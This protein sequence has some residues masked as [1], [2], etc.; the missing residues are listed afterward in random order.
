MSE[1]QETF[2][3]IMNHNLIAINLTHKDDKNN[4][5]SVIVPE[6]MADKLITI[7]RCRGYQI[8]SRQPATGITQDS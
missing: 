3:P 8:D 7:L 2:T 5:L 1:K 4:L 6:P